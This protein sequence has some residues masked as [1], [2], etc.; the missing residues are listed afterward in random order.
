MTP[1]ANEIFNS[2]LFAVR[3]PAAVGGLENAVAMMVSCDQADLWMA[4]NHAEK[5]GNIEVCDLIADA[6]QATCN[7]YA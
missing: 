6:I 3:N 2:A 7:P 1:A 5:I 4:Y